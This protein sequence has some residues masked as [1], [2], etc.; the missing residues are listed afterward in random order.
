MSEQN[1]PV[2]PPLTD[3]QKRAI[4]NPNPN[5]PVAKCG[6]CGMVLQQVMGF[7]CGNN[8]CPIQPRIR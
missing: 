6:Q 7:V 3:E 4:D 1:L 2:I 5:P 8:Y